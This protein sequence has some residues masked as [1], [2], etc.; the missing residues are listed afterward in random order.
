MANDVGFIRKAILEMD[1]PFCL[2]DLYRRLEKIGVTDRGLILRVLDELY[3][4]GLIEYDKIEQTV[5]E[6]VWGFKI[7]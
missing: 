7:A 2:I 5:D 4:E 6:P 1:K 3:E